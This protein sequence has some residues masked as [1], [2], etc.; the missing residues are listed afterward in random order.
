MPVSENVHYDAIYMSFVAMPVMKSMYCYTTCMS[1][2][3]MLVVENVHYYA[4]CMSLSE[5]VES[6]HHRA[7]CMSLFVPTHINFHSTTHNR[8]NY[9]MLYYANLFTDVSV[10][11]D[12]H[13]IGE[14]S[15][16]DDVMDCEDNSD[17]APCRKFNALFLAMF[18]N[19]K[20]IRNKEP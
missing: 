19:K 9:V 15:I 13:I 17:E 1:F 4:T 8:R 7:T 16:C 14:E 11:D 12:G 10:C 20:T 2:V 3:G 18:S 6:F 5:F